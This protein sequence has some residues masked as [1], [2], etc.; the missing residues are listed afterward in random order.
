MCLLLKKRAVFFKSMRLGLHL[1][2]HL[3]LQ[4]VGQNMCYKHPYRYKK[5]V[6]TANKMRFAPPYGHRYIL[7]ALFNY[8]IY[9]YLRLCLNFEYRKRYIFDGIKWFI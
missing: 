1:G 7:K 3:G 6:K 4:V 5:Q 9:R 8:Q 2:L